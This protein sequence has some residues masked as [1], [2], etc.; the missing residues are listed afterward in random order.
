MRRVGLALLLVLGVAIAGAHPTV[1]GAANLLQNGAFDVDVAGWEPFTTFTW[2]AS[3]DRDGNPASGGAEMRVTT[4]N[5]LNTGTVQCV[6]IAP[7]VPYITT[8]DVLVPTQSQAGGTIAGL[9]RIYFDSPDCAG[10]QIANAYG[11]SATALDEWQALTHTH[12]SPAGARSMWIYLNLYKT[13]I[14]AANAVAYWDNVRLYADNDT[15][16][17]GCS[18]VEEAGL[19]HEL[20][21]DRDPNDAWDFYDVTDDTYIDLSDALAIL[22]LFGI[23]V[24]DRGY[25]AAYDRYSPV[26]LK[27]WLTAAAIDGNGIDLTDALVNLDSFGD[28]CSALP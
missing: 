25:I 23:G 13:V 26:H 10:S 6:D 14:T 5:T 4:V 12:T 11:D 28:D 8:A 21:G 17:D 2:N 9:L 24:L 20:G 15:D 7:G 19:V 18:D 3:A 27:P 1:R 22:G 16:G